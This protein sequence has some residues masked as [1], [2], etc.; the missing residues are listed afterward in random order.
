MSSVI[1]FRSVCTA[2]GKD[3]TQNVVAHVNVE[4]VQYLSALL[5]CVPAQHGTAERRVTCADTTSTASTS[6]K[7]MLAG[8]MAGAF[9]KTCTAPFGRMTIL[10]Q[11]GRLDEHSSIV[12]GMR[13]IVASQVSSTMHAA[14]P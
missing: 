5:D 14:C 9:S 4:D 11:I 7:V 10:Y 8:G 6:M 2:R 13:H 3:S 12:G 1:H